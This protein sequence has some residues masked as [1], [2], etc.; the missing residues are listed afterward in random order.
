MTQTDPPKPDDLETMLQRA[1]QDPPALPPGL[2]ARVIADGQRLQP[3][4]VGRKRAESLS[5]GARLLAAMGGWPAVS[6]LAAASCAGFWIGYAPPEGMIDAG[7]LLL[8]TSGTVVYDDAAE[9]SG[10]GWDLEEG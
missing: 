1:A 3:S 9:L 5:L 2:A 4:P 8:N 7:D 6:G 10:F